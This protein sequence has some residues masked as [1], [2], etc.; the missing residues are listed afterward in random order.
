MATQV[1]GLRLSSGAAEEP[2]DPKE[3]WGLLADLD[4]LSFS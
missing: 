4:A 2:R 3:R 1:E